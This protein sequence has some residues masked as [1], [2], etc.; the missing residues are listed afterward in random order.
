[1]IYYTDDS[2]RRVSRFDAEQRVC[3]T[4]DFTLGRWVFDT[5]VFGTQS[6]DLWLDEITQEEAE[7]IMMKRDKALHR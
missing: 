4:Y 7:A 2:R 3:E 5:E 6:G 1:M